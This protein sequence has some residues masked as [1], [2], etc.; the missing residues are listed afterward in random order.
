MT[1]M[2]RVAHSKL[3]NGHEWPCNRSMLDYAT[4]FSAWE[5]LSG[6]SQLKC[7]VAITCKGSNL[8]NS[9]ELPQGAEPGVGDRQLPISSSV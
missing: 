6:K 4:V 2:H 9:E 8:P 1:R 5:E 3:P 7:T